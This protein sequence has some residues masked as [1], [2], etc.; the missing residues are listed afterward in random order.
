MTHYVWLNT[1][2]G[3]FSQSWTVG[4]KYI[5]PTEPGKPMQIP[6]EAQKSL[7]AAAMEARSLPEHR[8]IKFECLNDPEFT[9]WSNFKLK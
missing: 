8:L 4:D 3:K 6:H 5:Y 9:F 2:T 1:I 7:E